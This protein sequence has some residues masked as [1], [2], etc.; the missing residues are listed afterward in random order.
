MAT[1]T[2]MEMAA[3]TGMETTVEARTKTKIRI[4]ATIRKSDPGKYIRQV[5]KTCLILFKSIKIGVSVPQLK[6]Q[7]LIEF[8]RRFT[9]RVRC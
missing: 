9:L 8:I 2:I 3:E 5:I 7:G 4:T 6:P 1:G